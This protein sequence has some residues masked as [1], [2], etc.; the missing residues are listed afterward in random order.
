MVESFIDKSF[1][2]TKPWRGAA[3]RQINPQFFP[4]QKSTQQKGEKK[5]ER[6]TL[7]EIVG[8]FVEG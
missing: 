2:I 5:Q 1:Q 4:P 3:K 8:I 6:V 7:K